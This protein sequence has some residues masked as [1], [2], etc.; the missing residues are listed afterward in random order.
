MK[1]K[2]HEKDK[3]VSLYPLKLEEALALFM[4][5]K[6]PDKKSMDKGKKKRPKLSRQKEN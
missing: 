2:K 3:P 4:N 5:W 6:P 1:L